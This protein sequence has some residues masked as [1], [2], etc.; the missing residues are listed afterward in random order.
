MGSQIFLSIF[1]YIT[2][3][4]IF[5]VGA[6]FVIGALKG[7]KILVDPP[8]KWYALFTDVLLRRIGKK[9]FFY[10]HL[11]VGIVFMCGAVWILLY[12]TR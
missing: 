12:A 2:V 3:S 7:M 10:Y 4:L 8:Q 5:G 1:F 6:F 11:V 9:S